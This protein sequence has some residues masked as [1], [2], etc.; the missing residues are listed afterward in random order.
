ML[1]AL[2]PGTACGAEPWRGLLSGC[3]RAPP[4]SALH[5]EGGGGLG[6]GRSCSLP[7]WRR[8]PCPSQPCCQ[9]PE[10][11]PASAQLWERH[12]LLRWSRST[13]VGSLSGAGLSH[14]NVGAGGAEAASP[15]S[16]LSWGPCRAVAESSQG[17]GG[18]QSCPRG[19]PGVH[20]SP[21][22]ALPSLLPATPLLLS[23][24]L[25]GPALCPPALVGLILGDLGMP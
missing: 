7:R 22:P 24:D 11:G 18:V 8:A 3:S 13:A 5:S 19:L 23:W 10:L 21:P 12:E 20:V 6:G 17:S 2:F 15:R 1:L 25:A 4:I 9:S 16:R 14:G